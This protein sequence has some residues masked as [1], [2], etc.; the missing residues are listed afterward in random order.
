MLIIIV[1]NYQKPFHSH[2]FTNDYTADV[3]SD[4]SLKLLS[5]ASFDLIVMTLIN[6]N[7]TNKPT[8]FHNNSF[9][10]AKEQIFGIPRNPLGNLKYRRYCA[11]FLFF[12]PYFSSENLIWGRQKS[13]FARSF[14]HFRW[15]HRY[16]RTWMAVTW[17]PI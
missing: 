14:E 6:S 7:K 10:K 3:K 12:I 4:K 1:L 15:N 2:S 5:T 9:H 17:L 11:G 13:K 8:C 16:L